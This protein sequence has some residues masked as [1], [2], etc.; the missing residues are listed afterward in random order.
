MRGDFERPGVD[1]AASRA[2]QLSASRCSYNSRMLAVPLHTTHMSYETRHLLLLSHIVAL[3]GGASCAS[4]ACGLTRRFE[5]KATLAHGT[6]EAADT[7]ATGARTQDQT[8]SWHLSYPANFARRNV[9]CKPAELPTPTGRAS[10][11]R[12]KAE[13]LFA[14]ASLDGCASSEREASAATGWA[15]LGRDG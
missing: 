4:S 1:I 10:N 3:G 12:N 13:I 7:H 8:K 9:I 11:A 6:S 5:L 14:A 15:S 2:A